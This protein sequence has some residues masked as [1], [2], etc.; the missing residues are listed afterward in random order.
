LREQ[1]AKAK[2]PETSWLLFYDTYWVDEWIG[3]FKRTPPP[4]PH[5]GPLW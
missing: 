3:M 2:L 1:A 5:E 4:E